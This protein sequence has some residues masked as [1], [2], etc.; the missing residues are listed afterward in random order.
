MNKFQA[1]PQ[2]FNENPRHHPPL[3]VLGSRCNPNT[4]Y[5]ED[6]VSQNF[7]SLSFLSNKPMNF[8]C[9]D[10]KFNFREKNCNPIPNPQV[11]S[12]TVH[13]NNSKLINDIPIKDSNP[14]Q[15]PLVNKTNPIILLESNQEDLEM[16]TRRH[17]LC[18]REKNVLNCDN[19]EPSQN[20]VQQERNVQIN[21]SH[22]SPPVPTPA[23]IIIDKSLI[24]VELPPVT[25]S[26]QS[27]NQIRENQDISQP[28]NLSIW[29]KVDDQWKKLL[30]DTGAAI[31]PISYNFY[32]KLLTSNKEKR[33]TLHPKDLEQ[34]ISAN[35]D[36]LS[37]R[38]MLTL[39]FEI[40]HIVYPIKTYVI[41]NLNYEI[42]LGKDFLTEYNGIIDFKHK[43][44]T[45]EPNISSN[46]TDHLSND[47]EID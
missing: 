19:S 12:K 42:I 14:T 31:T 40:C 17:P 30:V 2:H 15:V 9:P 20:T 28:S 11:I 43:N 4:S 10:S 38:G 16:A 37:I 24:P 45:L 13:D 1:K 18:L 33:R 7:M 21:Q 22:E 44:L 47:E 8:S 36:E 35:G 41:D 5:D 6:L 26:N 23:E 39:Y 32:S 34:V 27:L 25:A 29:G 46:K 3:N